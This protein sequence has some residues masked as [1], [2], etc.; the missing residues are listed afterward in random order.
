MDKN[1]RIGAIIFD[2]G[3]TLMDFPGEWGVVENLGRKNLLK[4]LRENKFPVSEEAVDYFGKRR[5]EGHHKAD[6]ELVEFTAEM[7]FRDMITKFG[8][9]GMENGVVSLALER[10]FAP[11]L[12]TWRAFPDSLS[13]LKALKKHGFL[14]GLISNATHHP[15]ILNCLDRFGFREYLNPALSSAAFHVRKP[16]PDIFH[17][18]ASQWGI[19]PEQIAVVGDQ[20]YFDIFGAHQAGMKG[21]WFEQE[22]D[23][24]HTF[25]PEELRNDDRLAPDHTIHALSELLE[26]LK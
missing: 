5:D 9:N 14:I 24:A 22:T 12:E 13:T 11:E 4:L 1:R 26:L 21:I 3:H 18:V 16:H 7:A 6:V 15:F 19:S 20:L 2:L 17:H 10:Y 23:K 25:I 8:L